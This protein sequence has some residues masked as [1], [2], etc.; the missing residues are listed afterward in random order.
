MKLA[1]TP[2]PGIEIPWVCD[3]CGEVIVTGGALH[4]DAAAG[5]AAV[6]AARA[7]GHSSLEEVMALPPHASWMAHH[8]GCGDT[9]DT[10]YWVD[11]KKVQT[12]KGLVEETSYLMDKAWLPGTT[13]G[14]V[15]AVAARG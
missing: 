2:V 9:D 3:D 12:F 13:W 1:T 5:G 8:V 7:I 11:I 14:S 6:T 10:D 4:V 15:L